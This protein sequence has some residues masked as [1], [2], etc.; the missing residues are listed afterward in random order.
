M[1]RM[2]NVILNNHERRYNVAEVI[3]K[4]GYIVPTK[5][6]FLNHQILLL[7]GKLY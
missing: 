2:F 3:I 5:Y 6:L 1:L 7:K 4:P